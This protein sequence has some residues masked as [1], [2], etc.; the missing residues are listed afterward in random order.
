MDDGLHSGERFR[1]ELFIPNLGKATKDEPLIVAINGLEGY[2]SSFL[3]EA[4]GDVVRAP[5]TPMPICWNVFTYG[6]TQKMAFTRT[7]FGSILS[8][9]RGGRDV[10]ANSRAKR[11]CL[12][13]TQALKRALKF[14]YKVVRVFE[15]DVHA[16]RLPC[17]LPAAVLPALPGIAG[18]Q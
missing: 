8:V 4:F 14:S 6:Q 17:V 12:R 15:A 5:C 7:S 16:H 1:E 11:Q 18:Y 3:E 10:K 9:R 13:Y 2:A